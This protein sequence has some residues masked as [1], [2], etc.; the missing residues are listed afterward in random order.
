MWQSFLDFNIDQDEPILFPF[1]DCFN[2]YLFIPDISKLRV[3]W[4]KMYL[5]TLPMNIK[6]ISALFQKPLSGMS[7]K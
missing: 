5:I 2:P 3:F 4:R 6:R 7:V 1:Q